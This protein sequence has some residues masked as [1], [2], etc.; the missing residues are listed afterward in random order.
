[1]ALSCDNRVIFYEFRLVKSE[2]GRHEYIDFIEIPFH[3]EL[4]FHPTSIA[5]CE[6]IVCCM[7]HQFLNLFKI[8][9]VGEPR[10]ISLSV[11]SFSSEICS[12][13]INTK[14][15]L[16]FRTIA[17]QKMLNKELFRVEMVSDMEDFGN[18]DIKPEVVTEMLIV[19]RGHGESELMNK[20]SIKSL[21]QL[22]MRSKFRS[23]CDSF[24]CLALK[25][26]YRV[27]ED[28][29]VETEN[30]FQS[31]YS[32]G[33]ISVA[34]CVAT[35]QDAYLYS[36][37]N[38]D[39]W[40]H[41]PELLASYSFTSPVIDLVLDDTVLHALTET[42]VETYTLRIGQKIFYSSCE[43]FMSS[44][45][46]EIIR[47]NLDDPVCLVGI[48]PFIGMKRIFSSGS[49]VILLANEASNMNE[50]TWTIYNL[51]KPRTETLYKNIEE[52][53]MRFRADNP[54]MFLSLMH[55]AHVIVRLMVE[56]VRVIPADEM[57]RQNL[58]A[59][60]LLTFSSTIEPVIETIFVDSC[61]ALA[62]YFVV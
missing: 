24:S 62:D 53:A 48:R 16:D 56:T 37:H 3:V 2:T 43:F 34:L 32:K 35:Q 28:N 52:F 50:P 60:P 54:K 21:L 20:Y 23:F 8:Q 45:Q 38:N 49:H 59:V 42:G 26:I 6:G 14:D 10:S 30:L 11:D 5:F 44:N 4:T 15:T 40:R 51:R 55:E 12:N 47:P 36:F 39:E 13:Q 9:K 58:K 7:D 33:V 27:T 18:C 61:R 41:Q 22:K 31:R 29:A 57:N 1:M 17:H 19:L 46:E 25:P